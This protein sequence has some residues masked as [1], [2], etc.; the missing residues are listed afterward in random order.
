M[1]PPGWRGY[2]LRLV[3]EPCIMANLC[4]IPLKVQPC[5]SH[6]PR[7]NNLLSSLGIY[8]TGLSLTWTMFP[9]TST[10]CS[11]NTVPLPFMVKGTPLLAVW[12]LNVSLSSLYSEKS[13]R[14]LVKVAEA[15]E[16]PMNSISP[17]FQEGPPYKI[18]CDSNRVVT[19]TFL[20]IGTVCG[21]AYICFY[22]TS[23]IGRTIY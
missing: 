23:T 20:T 15:P 14:S 3:W 22:I 12:A 10:W 4:F 17:F 6:S 1:V 5:C 13:L 18:F 8:K 2:R 11:K 19:L 7:D 21:Q 9:N 16:S